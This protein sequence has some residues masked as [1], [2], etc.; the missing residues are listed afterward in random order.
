MSKLTSLTLTDAADLLKSRKIS[1]VEL[2]DAYLDNIEKNDPDISAYITV[3][4]ESARLSALSADNAINC[5]KISLLTGIPYALKDNLC[6]SG[7]RTTCASK[8]LKDFIP[9]YNATVYDTLRKENAVLLGKTNMDEFSMGSSTENSFFGRTKNPID[10]SRIPGGSSG[11][12]AAAVAANEALFAIGSDTGGSVRQ[13]AALCGVVAMNPT[14]SA[15]SRYGLIAFASSL[16]RV[17]TITKNVKDNAYLLSRLCKKDEKD[18]TNIGITQDLLLGIDSGVSNMHLAVIENLLSHAS[19]DVKN[20]VLSSARTLE[21]LGAMVDMISFS[22]IELAL[23]AYYIISSAEASSN[24]AR[25]DGIRYGERFDNSDSLEEYFKASRSN[26]LGD[27]VKR[28]IIIGTQLLTGEFREKYYKKALS[29]KQRIKES[30]LDIFKKYDA[31][32]SPTY[33]TVAPKADDLSSSSVYENDIMTVPQSVAGIPSLT[34]PCS[35]DKNGLPIGIQISG[36]P[37]SEQTLYRI[38]Y[39]LES[40]VYPR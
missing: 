3:C 18:S 8:M 23:S 39:A 24:L 32:L 20:A 37:F 40:E 19:E 9:P 35:L 21:K 4:R 30:F 14:Y 33:P 36:A 25:Y 31:I 6:T 22:D 38:G 2:T 16:D 26:A 12:S 17:G 7:I 1:S 13:P 28:R 29:A 5:G 34:L 27:E 10:T 15:I 11:G